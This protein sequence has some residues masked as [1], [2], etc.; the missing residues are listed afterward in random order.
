[1]PPLSTGHPDQASHPA[2]ASRT[3]L[4]LAGLQVT[5]AAL[6]FVLATGYVAYQWIADSALSYELDQVTAP[7]IFTCC[8]AVAFGL[9]VKGSRANIAIVAVLPV[10]AQ[11]WMLLWRAPLYDWPMQ[12]FLMPLGELTRAPYPAMMLAADLL[13]MLSIPLGVAA[14]A[15]VA[16]GARSAAVGTGAM[17][18]VAAG[19]RPRWCS[20]CW[21]SAWQ[22][23]MSCRFGSLS[24]LSV[25]LCC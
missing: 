3:V 24:W 21:R 14:A 11:A 17:L 19:G 12:V 1:M 13:A 23:C 7:L 16:V 10:V 20:R 2:K 4:L 9:A 6:A 22:E 5:S 18:G 15:A 8:A 25:R